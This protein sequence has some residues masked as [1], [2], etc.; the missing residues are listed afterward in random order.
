MA[1]RLVRADRAGEASRRRCRAVVL[2]DCRGALTRCLEQA[3]LRRGPVMTT[4]GLEGFFAETRDYEATAAFWASL[5]FQ[6][7]FETGRGAGQWV[8]PGA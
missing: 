6:S 4:E 1:A 3:G 7:A 5:G 2:G 8:H